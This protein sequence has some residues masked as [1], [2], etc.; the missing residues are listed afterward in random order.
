M[1]G[2][3]RGTTGLGCGEE[4]GLGE[5]STPCP[6]RAPVGPRASPLGVVAL[7]LRKG[8]AREP[9]GNGTPPL[10]IPLH[11]GDPLGATAFAEPP[12]KVPEGNVTR[13]RLGPPILDSAPATTLACPCAAPETQELDHTALWLVN[14]EQSG[15]G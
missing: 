9:G 11:M 3:S 8:L 13:A 5:V 4:G 10:K 2:E 14:G 7:S 6:P 15:G 12:Q 1:G